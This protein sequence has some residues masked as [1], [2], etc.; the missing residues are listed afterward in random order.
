MPDLADAPSTLEELDGLALSPG[1]N[2]P[3]PSVSPWKE[4]A[5]AKQRPGYFLAKRVLDVTLALVG[6]VLASPVM[7]LAWALVRLTS[8]GS[9]IFRQERVG[10]HGRR[11]VVYKFRS[12][13]VDHDE[14]LHQERYE[15]FMRGERQHKGSGV[16]HDPRITPIG[17]LL[18][19]SSVDE[20]P[21]LVNVLRGEMSVVG[22]RPPM[23]SEVSIYQPWHLGRLETL[24]GITGL[25]QVQGRSRVSFETMVKMDIEYIQRQSFWYDLKLICL[26]VPAI[27][28]RKGAY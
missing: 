28:S 26:T 17:Y 6:L 13:Y 2:G 8:H 25:W 14:Q 3:A 27:L 22:P 18:R 20:L 16:P 12:M 19:R 15:P 4:V 9:A 10:F 24:P 21:Q 5:L 11:F 23:P 1:A 7:L